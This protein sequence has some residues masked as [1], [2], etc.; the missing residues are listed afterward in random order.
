MTTLQSPGLFVARDRL[1]GVDALESPIGNKGTAFTEDGRRRIGLD[2]LPPLHVESVDQQVVCAYEAYRPKD[3]DLER[4][5]YLRVLQHISGVLFYRLGEHRPSRTDPYGPLLPV[6]RD[7]RAVVREIASVVGLE[8]QRAWVGPQS[9]PE[10][11][12]DRVAAA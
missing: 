7:V 11:L 5:V 12:R 9:S 4:H 10:E 8:A 6:L 3:G 1:R 2:G